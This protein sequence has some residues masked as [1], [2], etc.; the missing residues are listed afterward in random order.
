MSVANFSISAPFKDIAKSV[1]ALSIG[2]EDTTIPQ[3]P[4]VMYPPQLNPAHG[5]AVAIDDH[6]LLTCAHT[7]EYN[8]ISRDYASCNLK[9]RHPQPCPMTNFQPHRSS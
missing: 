2:F 7:L 8:S 6:H 3:D 1:F 5:T 9:Y 4:N